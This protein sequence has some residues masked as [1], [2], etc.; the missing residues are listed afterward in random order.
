MKNLY[1]SNNGFTSINVQQV[2]YDEAELNEKWDYKNNINY[3]DFNC[4]ITAFTL[5]KDY[6]KS[7]SKFSGDDTTLIFDIDAIENNPLS[8][9]TKEDKDK[10]INLYGAIK[11]ENTQDIQKHVDEIK[12]E[13]KNRKISFIK[14]KNVSMINVFLHDP[15]DEILFVGHSGISVKTKD[16]LLFIEKYGFSLP[17]QVSKFK[18]KAELKEYLMDRLDV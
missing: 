2:P 12:K 3:M 7:N 5:F 14:N 17:Y 16:G 15:E 13:W 10:F 18:D 6:I 1:T 9:F 8:E 11:A 4:R